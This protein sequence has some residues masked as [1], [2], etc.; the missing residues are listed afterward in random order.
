MRASLAAGAQNRMF[1]L[2]QLLYYNQGPENSGWLSQSLLEAAA[3]SLPGVDVA[4]LLEEMDADAVSHRLH[5]DASEAKRRGV[6]ATPT[7][8]VGPTGGELSHV[9]LGSPDD[10]EA[11]EQ[12]IAAAQ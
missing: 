10:L 9:T 7:I 1:E 11:L 3:R 2:M 12:A 6:K 4:R 8:F 5:E